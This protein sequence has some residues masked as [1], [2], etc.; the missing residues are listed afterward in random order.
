[1]LTD[2]TEANDRDEKRCLARDL[3]NYRH[4]FCHCLHK[5]F[6]E[7]HLL[8]HC[9]QVIYTLTRCYSDAQYRDTAINHKTKPQMYSLS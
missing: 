7:R 3:N 6:G 1:M 4:H 2:A 8:G 5:D 9:V